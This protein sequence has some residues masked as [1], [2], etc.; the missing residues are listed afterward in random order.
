[1]QSVVEN[2]LN[3]DIFDTVSRNSERCDIFFGF[4]KITVGINGVNGAAFC[5]FDTRYS[6]AYFLISVI[7]DG[8]SF[9][10]SVGCGEGVDLIGV[11]G[12]LNTLAQRV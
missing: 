11:G 6:Y 3:F 10:L 8:D 1:M 7:Y 9:L 5:I 4:L 12:A 2:L